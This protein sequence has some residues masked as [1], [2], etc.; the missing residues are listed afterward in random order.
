MNVDGEV[1]SPTAER[2]TGRLDQMKPQF[3]PRTLK[4]WNIQIP[5]PPQLEKGIGA[6][7]GPLEQLKSAFGHPNNTQSK[8]PLLMGSQGHKYQPWSHSD[9]TAVLAKLPPITS[10]GGRWLTKL[11]ALCHGTTLAVGDLRCLLGQILTASQMR[12]FEVNAD[13]TNSPNDDPYTTVC[14]NVGSTLRK[15]FPTPPTTYQNI[16]FRIKPG[17]TGS[18]YYFR[19]AAEWEQMVEENSLNNPITRDI[20]RSAV[21]SGAPNG[22]KQAMEGNPDIP[23]ATNEVWERHL[24]FHIDRTVDKLHKEEE[25]LEKTKNQLL[26]LQL[27][28][29]RASGSKKTKQMS[30]Q[31]VN[32]P[33]TPSIIS[34]YLGYDQ[35]PTYQPPWSQMGNWGGYR[36]QR[37]GNMGFKGRRGRGGEP[38]RGGCFLCGSPDHWKNE[39]PS[40][41]GGGQFT[42]PPAGGWGPLRGGPGGRGRGPHASQ[43]PGQQHPSPANLQ[44]PMHPTWGP[45]GDAGDCWGPQRTT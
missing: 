17:E 28:L 25:E 35:G 44:A 12:D 37:G 9:M 34:P 13:I 23:V 10:G 36:V 7:G 21:M 8:Y 1:T 32:D 42:G 29:A 20:F 31:S 43:Y 5:S 45:E 39:C 4:E 40:Q 14:T 30:Q 24:V 11:M 22:V 33:P 19:C 38:Q 6:S 27:D 18:G 16:K 2:T 26:K 15:Q 41:Q 3:T